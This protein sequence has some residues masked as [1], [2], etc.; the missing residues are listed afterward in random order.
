[1]KTFKIGFSN[2]QTIEAVQC[3]IFPERNFTN[4]NRFFVMLGI[5]V[6]K[7]FQDKLNLLIQPVYQTEKE[8]KFHYNLTIELFKGNDLKLTPKT[9][10]EMQSIMKQFNAIRKALKE[11]KSSGKDVF[12][13]HGHEYNVYAQHMIDFI[14]NNEP[15]LI[16]VDDC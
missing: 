6:E 11:W 8:H 4:V 5:E 3:T 10:K 14:I 1:M 2:T 16:V 9:V 12:L 13:A 7:H 15:S